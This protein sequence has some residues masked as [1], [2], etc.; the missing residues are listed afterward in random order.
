MGFNSGFKGLTRNH[1]WT[2]LGLD[3]GLR[4]NIYCSLKWK[5][6]FGRSA[7]WIRSGI[8]TYQWLFLWNVNT[9]L[10]TDANRRPEVHHIVCLTTGSQPLPKRVLRGVR[11]SASSINF[12]YLLIYLRLS[13]SCLPHLPHLSLTSTFLLSFLQYAWCDQSI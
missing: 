12:L 10:Q 5:Y 11:S 1:K 6:L 3:Q 13:G 2:M 4:G 7:K 9:L 8:S